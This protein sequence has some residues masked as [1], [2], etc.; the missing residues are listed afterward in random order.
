MSFPNHVD[1][2]LT[3]NVTNENAIQQYNNTNDND[4]PMM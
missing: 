2:L 4:S 1:H 3:A